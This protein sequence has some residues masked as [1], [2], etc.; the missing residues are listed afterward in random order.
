MDDSQCILGSNWLEIRTEVLHII[1]VLWNPG[2]NGQFTYGEIVRINIAENIVGLP[3]NINYYPV[4]VTTSNQ[5]DQYFRKARK[6]HP[7]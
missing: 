3:T 7:C 6:K 4:I 5:C 1:V 2:N